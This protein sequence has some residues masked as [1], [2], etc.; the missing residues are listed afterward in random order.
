MHRW[1]SELNFD[2][3]S[4]DVVT[5]GHEV[6]DLV[7]VPPVLGQLPPCHNLASPLLSTRTLPPKVIHHQAVTKFKD[8]LLHIHTAT[9]LES[10]NVDIEALM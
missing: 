9:D 4:T 5:A 8:V 10:L 2:I 6:R 7:T 1:L 3:M